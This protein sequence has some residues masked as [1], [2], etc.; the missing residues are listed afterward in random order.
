VK[1]IGTEDAAKRL[2]V[3]DR[4]VRQLI[5]EGK[6]SAQYVGGG[7]VIEESA[8]ARVT[9]YGKAGRPAQKKRNGKKQV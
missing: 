4:R 3:S 6:L 8:L 9:V 7:Y 5:G 1:L 2:G